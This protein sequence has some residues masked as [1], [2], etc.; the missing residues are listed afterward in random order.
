[1]LKLES[2][3]V[4]SIVK[5]VGVMLIAVAIIAVSEGA[6]YVYRQYVSKVDVG[7]GIKIS[8]SEYDKY[9]KAY[10]PDI[11]DTAFE[12]ITVENA[13]KELGIELTEDELNAGLQE[14]ESQAWVSGKEYN[15]YQAEID[16]K[17]MLLSDKAVEYYK[18]SVVVPEEELNTAVS[19]QNEFTKVTGNYKKVSM[20]DAQKIL[21][22]GI[23]FGD[24]GNSVT[25][26]EEG[27]TDGNNV[28]DPM[29]AIVGGTS[30][31]T[32]EDGNIMFIQVASLI[33]DDEDIR[34]QMEDYIKQ[35]KATE[36]F[37]DFLEQVM[38]RT[39]E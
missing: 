19:V 35:E 11:K 13:L 37:T 28:D 25:V 18:Q 24:I 30:M 3:K 22:E 23:S 34:S 5:R 8:R 17:V 6:T 31:Y 38:G 9:M 33:N 26:I 12:M 29:S 27:T 32:D 16:T 21:D 2:N 15:E 1:M 4:K 36:Q 20:E 7:G 10:E 14:Y 39:T